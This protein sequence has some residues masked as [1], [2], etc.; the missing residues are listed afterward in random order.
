MGFVFSAAP[1]SLF[2]RP[3]LAHQHAL[4]RR[5]C[6]S[7]GIWMGLAFSLIESNAPASKMGKATY[8]R[9]HIFR[10]FRRQKNF[11]AK[12]QFGCCCACAYGNVTDTFDAPLPVTP[13]TNN[14][15]A[16]VG[17][18]PALLSQP[19]LCQLGFAL[20]PSLPPVPGGFGY[21]DHRTS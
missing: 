7:H 21:T 5:W 9:L 11:E 18:M 20:L 4:R 17:S 12:P 15:T 3:L 6:S 13:C 19:A 8:Q 14:P 2:Q 16:F 10:I 1:S